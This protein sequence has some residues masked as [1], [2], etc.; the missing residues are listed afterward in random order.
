MFNDYFVM[1]LEGE[2]F[3]GFDEWIRGYTLFTLRSNVKWVFC[4]GSIDVSQ[5]TGT[6]R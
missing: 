2:R 5:S 1:N 3:L 4:M 6:I